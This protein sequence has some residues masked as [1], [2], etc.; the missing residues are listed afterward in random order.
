MDPG[1]RTVEAGAPHGGPSATPQSLWCHDCRAPFTLPSLV[2]NEDPRCVSCDGYFVE[3]QAPHG[4]GEVHIS[5]GQHAS[6]IDVVDAARQI[7][8]RLAGAEGVPGAQTVGTSTG[9]GNNQN[10]SSQND[11]PEIAAVAR[12][13]WTAL[14]GHGGFQ[15]SNTFNNG[16]GFGL[17]QGGGASFAFGGGVGGQGA[18]SQ[19]SNAFGNLPPGAFDAFGEVNIAELDTRT[20]HQPANEEVVANLPET[21][22]GPRAVTDADEDRICPVCLAEMEEGTLVKEMPCRHLYHKNCLLEWLRTKNSCPVCRV[23]LPESTNTS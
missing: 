9:Q 23:V 8:R 12:E 5:L 16:S 22:A 6:A 13:A 19:T 14:L 4:N 1:A 10:A 15:S 21:T 17:T 20:F 7:V 3:V 18:F 2:P 11:E